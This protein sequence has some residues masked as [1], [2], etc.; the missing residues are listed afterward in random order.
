MLQKKLDDLKA[1][2]EKTEQ[3]QTQTIKEDDILEE[4]ED[5]FGA[6]DDKKKV[7]EAEF[8]G[9][10]SVKLEKSEKEIENSNAM[11]TTQTIKDDAAFIYAEL[12]QDSL[13][14]VNEPGS[15]REIAIVNYEPR[16]KTPADLEDEELVDL[17]A[18]F[19][20][21]FDD[22]VPSNPK[23]KSKS[24]ITPKKEVV[25]NNQTPIPTEEDAE[26]LEFQRQ[27]REMDAKKQEAEE[28]LEESRKQLKAEEQKELD[29][30]EKELKEIE[31]EENLQAQKMG[32]GLNVPDQGQAGD[33]TS[34]VSAYKIEGRLEVT[35]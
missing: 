21:N 27:L 15:F 19:D 12:K 29:D 7:S 30:I 18:D 28:Q 11:P 2:N 33:M 10:K 9:D 4:F 13:R 32:G 16:V 3:E 20:D 14:M 1:E 5:D 26:E 31:A 22:D 8:E 25:S 24:E 17:D 6:L 35:I 34:Q 23:D